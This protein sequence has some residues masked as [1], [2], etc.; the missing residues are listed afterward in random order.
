MNTIVRDDADQAKNTVKLALI[1]CLLI[2]SSIA[3]AVSG[4][5]CAQ[6]RLMVPAETFAVGDA[7]PPEPPPNDPDSRKSPT[8]PLPP[9][10]L[11][12]SR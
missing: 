4:G 5:R 8:L 7:G 11:W 6:E 1:A 2:L 10:A 12:A 9:P 3:L